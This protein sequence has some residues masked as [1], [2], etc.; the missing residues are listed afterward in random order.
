MLFVAAKV[1]HLNLLP[2]GQPE[3]Y[4]RVKAMV[5]AME[6]EQFGACSN[7]R[8]CEAACPKGISISF[9]ARMNR[10]YRKALWKTKEFEGG[11]AEGISKFR[12]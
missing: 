10:D 3:R 7:H 6:K 9:I 4:R 2:Q 5:E 11:K 1:S 12:G 8:E